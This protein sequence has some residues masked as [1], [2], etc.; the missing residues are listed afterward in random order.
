ML[1]VSPTKN[2]SAYTASVKMSRQN[3]PMPKVLKMSP[4]TRMV[5]PP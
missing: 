4:M 2:G 5:A 3:R 1:A